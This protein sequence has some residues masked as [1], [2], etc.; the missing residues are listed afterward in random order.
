L[1]LLPGLPVERG[2]GREGLGT[3]DRFGGRLGDVSVVESEQ[4]PK[5]DVV[6]VLTESRRAAASSIEIC[7]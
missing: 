6:V 5:D 4:P 2:I 7:K 3:D 1:I